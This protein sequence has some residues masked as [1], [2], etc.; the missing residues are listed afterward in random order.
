MILRGLSINDPWNHNGT[1]GFLRSKEKQTDYFP[2]FSWW[3]TV[4]CGILRANCE[5]VTEMLWK[6]N[7]QQRQNVTCCLQPKE[8]DS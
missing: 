7:V 8:E 2:G 1:E 4:F 5:Q 3:H 6:S